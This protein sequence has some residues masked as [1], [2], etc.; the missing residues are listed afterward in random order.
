MGRRRRR[1]IVKHVTRS[2]PKVFPCVV[3]GRRSVS[4][5]IDR[6]KSIATV[7]CSSCGARGEVEVKPYMTIVD[8]YSS[9]TDLLYSG[10]LNVEGVGK[11]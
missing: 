4:V 6:S 7:V 5:N 8:A 1:K 3:C 11:A 10:K 9:W 2:L